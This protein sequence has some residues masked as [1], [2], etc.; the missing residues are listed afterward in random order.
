MLRLVFTADN[1]LNRYYAKMARE[2]LRERRKRI[3]EA[4]RATVDFAIQHRAHFYL[5]GGDLFDQPDPSPA[6]LT[7][8]AQQFQRLREAGIHVLCISGN[9]DMPRAFDGA[10]PVRIYDELRAAHVF[11]KRAEV[12]FLEFSVEKTRVAIGGLAPDPRAEPGADVLADVDIQPPRADVALLLLH[13]GVESANPPDFQDA[14]L[15]KAR[16]SALKDVHYFLVGNLHTTKKLVVDHA[17]VIIPGA[18]ERYNFGE[19]DDEPG[20]YYLELEGKDAVKLTRHK[21]E[22]QKMDRVTVRTTDLPD[23]DP[24]KYIVETIR[25]ASDRDQLLQLRLEGPL[26]RDLYHRLKFFDLW[27]IGNESNFFFDLDKA[28]IELRDANALSTTGGQVISP[29][30]EI[31]RVAQELAANAPDEP[32]RALIADARD[33]V[34]NRYRQET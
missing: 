33:L 6:E 20:F 11:M 27:Q 30:R 1:H 29:A 28:N 18:T 8:V 19:M 13:A 31:E 5:H 22:P 14:T 2:Q 7:F 24:T 9:H 23:D 10:T 21:V 15:T 25:A 12:E 32:T 26:S 4:W 34:L 17:T 3:R 16:V